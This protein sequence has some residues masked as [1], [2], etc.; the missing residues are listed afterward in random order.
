MVGVGIFAVGSIVLIPMVWRGWVSPFLGP[1]RPRRALLL[2]LLL[3]FLPAVIL[4]VLS[5]YELAAGGVPEPPLG[6]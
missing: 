4:L 3:F 1:L 6:F 5:I 2:F